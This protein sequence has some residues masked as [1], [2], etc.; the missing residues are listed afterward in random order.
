MRFLAWVLGLLFAFG[1]A[2]VKP[3]ETDEELRDKVRSHI[4]V[5]VDESAAILDD[6]AESLR[7]DERVQDAERFLQD[8]IDVTEETAEDLEDVLDDAC[9]R[10]DERFGTD[11][12]AEG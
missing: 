11:A 8:V 5:I 6:V 10:I 4:D 7:E 9:A 3:A 2:G 1:A 12:S